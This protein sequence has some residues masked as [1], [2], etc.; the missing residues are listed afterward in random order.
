[1]RNL[2]LDD[3]RDAPHEDFDV[4]RNYSQFVNYIL[5]KDMPEIISFDHDLGEEKTGYDCMKYLVEYLID[6]PDSFHPFVNVHSQNPV[7]AE[8]IFKYWQSFEKH[9][10][11]M[12]NRFGENDEK[13]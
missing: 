9:F 5:T 6:N 2:Y 12:K 13:S 3:V 7:G 1:M 11:W 10:L 8:N 4:V